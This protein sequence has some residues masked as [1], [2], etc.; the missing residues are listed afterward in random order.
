MPGTASDL[1]DSSISD[2]QPCSKTDK[3][4]NSA[5]C[6]HD[7]T[8][9]DTLVSGLIG[10]SCTR[11]NIPWY[12]PK[13]A[14]RGA[15]HW[16]GML[17]QFGDVLPSNEEARKL[18][19]A[20][21]AQ[22]PEGKHGIDGFCPS[23]NFPFG[24]PKNSSLVLSKLEIIARLPDGSLCDSL[25]ERYLSVIEGTH[26]LFH[27]PSLKSE[28]ERFWLDPATAT[29]GW[30][31][32]FFM[33]LA[34][35]REATEQAAYDD[36][37]LLRPVFLE[38]AELCLSKTPVLFRA[39]TTLIRCL[40]LAV[41]VKLASVYQCS[42]IDSCGVLTDMAVRSCMELGLH[43]P[44]GGFGNTEQQI[45]ARLWTAAVFLKV[46]QAANS[47]TPLLLRRCDFEYCGLRNLN[48]DELETASES[49]PL[50]RY[51][52]STCQ[53]IIA[54]ALPAAIDIVSVANS[55]DGN[56]GVDRLVHHE[57]Q[58]ISLLQDVQTIYNDMEAID[59]FGWRR[60]Q[61]PMLEVYLRRM[62]LIT[63]QANPP[64]PSDHLSKTYSQ[65]QFVGSALAILVHQRQILEAIECAEMRMLAGLHKQDFFI[66]AVG[67]CATLRNSKQLEAGLDGWGLD[68]WGL[69]GWGLGLSA[70]STRETIRDALYWCKELW[71]RDVCRST[72]N[73]WAYLILQRLLD[74]M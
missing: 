4:E 55:A 5:I 66:A 52:E 23:E 14:L 12:T 17:G 46:Q 26:H 64:S 51:T 50:L 63:H 40:C 38:S 30:L 73:F 60:L 57:R 7:D 19:D 39:D 9:C 43:K 58:M 36:D 31:A 53:I 71:A 11:T 56:A 32:Q 59:S 45:R 18:L 49:W 47:G 16:D 74:G 34:L 25:V 61:R 22:Q 6:D 41:I 54:E 69:D 33:V 72:C 28:I 24:R 13:S 29:Y 21:L 37:N 70:A 3:P 44:S 67:A 10:A 2:C 48:D 62:L 68:G 42:V 20:R 15:T 65:Q 8:D 1:E 27:M 35:G